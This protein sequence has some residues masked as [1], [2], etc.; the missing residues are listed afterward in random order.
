MK[1]K[2]SATNRFNAERTRGMNRGTRPGFSG[3][4][5]AP[6]RVPVGKGKRGGDAYSR[7]VNAASHIIGGKDGKK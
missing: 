7:E 3:K 1:R 6:I 4:A 2:A 5:E